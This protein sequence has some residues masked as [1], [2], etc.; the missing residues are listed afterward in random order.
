M[1]Q[2]QRAVRER[3][4]SDE[5]RNDVREN[6]KA[7]R[8]FSRIMMLPGLIIGLVC[9]VAG[10]IPVF[11]MSFGSTFKSWDGT[12]ALDC[13]G[14]E[15]ASYSGVTANLT[16]TAVYARG[17]CRLTLEDCHITAATGIE[18]SGNAHV[19]IRGGSMT[20]Q[21]FV[22]A[23]GNATVD[24]RG[25]HVSGKVKKAHNSHVTGVP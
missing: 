17:N 12:T 16:G 23:S 1:E 11:R 5:I 14:N 2:R 10:L 22:D 6:Q 4:I 24:N 19:I 7:A 8:N 20:T 9:V 15:N 25:G 3:Q 13:D 18:A 21:T